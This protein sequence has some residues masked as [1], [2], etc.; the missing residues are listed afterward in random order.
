MVRWPRS[1]ELLTSLALSWG[2]ATALAG[3]S[4]MAAK[5][6]ELPSAEAAQ[7]AIAEALNRDRDQLD[8]RPLAPHAKLQ[9]V[10]Q[11]QA[12]GLER[13]GSFTSDLVTIETV[14]SWLEES[15]Y[16][17]RRLVQ[18]LVLSDEPLAGLAAF[19]ALNNPQS[20]QPFLDGELRDLGVGVARVEGAPVYMVLAAFSAETEFAQ[21][22]AALA[23]LGAV[24]REMLER[25]NRERRAEGLAPLRREVH[26]EAAAQSYAEQMLREDFYGHVSPRGE[27]VLDRAKAAGYEVRLVGENI[28]S[29]PGSVEVVM[30]GWMDSPPH[31]ANLLSPK[32]TDFG[33]GL[34]AGKTAEGPKILWVQCFGR[35]Q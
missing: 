5:P 11:R 30:D 33:M 1:A 2:L 20:Y 18:S 28:A 6:L 22:T 7:H 25:V 10:A 27:T 35:K 17:P 16:T 19:W 12:D 3:S 14:A 26:L 4:A 21:Q 23:D 29:G 13:H 15:G 9:R 31:R 24:R 34:A 8:L 32:F